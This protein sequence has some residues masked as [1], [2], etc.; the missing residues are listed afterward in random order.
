M[1]S[2]KI[3]TLSASIILI[4]A[5]SSGGGDNPTTDTPSTGIFIDSIV[6][7]LHYQTTTQ[8][9]Y[10]NTSGEYIY[11]PD[12]IVTFSIGGIILGSTKAGPVITPLNLVPGAIDA[13]NSTVTNIA[14]LLLTLDADGNPDNGIEITANVAAATENQSVDFSVA[15]LATDPGLIALL[16][17]L[18]GTPTLVDALSAQTHFSTTLAA[19]SNWRGMAWGNG[20]W[21]SKIP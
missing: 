14:R 8:S 15:D 9:G 1:Y 18:P 4:S 13:S 7:G 2:N 10:T 3:L 12:E 19:Q 20:T 5:C 21:Q 11:L 16:P 17:L 6:T